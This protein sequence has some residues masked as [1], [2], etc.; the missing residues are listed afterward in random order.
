MSLRQ[1]VREGR[2][3]IK[4]AVLWILCLG[5][6]WT[7]FLYVFRP[8]AYY[9]V[10][11]GILYGTSENNVIYVAKPHD[12][13]FDKAPQGN[14]ECHFERRISVIPAWASDPVRV[15]VTWEK[16]QERSD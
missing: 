15:T 2:R 7:A 4:K 12:C 5:V 11:Y 13:D 3:I 1:G 16:V 6:L 9:G 10:L 14:K 8:Q